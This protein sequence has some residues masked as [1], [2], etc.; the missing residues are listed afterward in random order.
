LGGGDDPDLIGRSPGAG[1][2]HGFREQTAIADETQD[3]LGTRRAAER[4]ESLAASAGQD[5]HMHAHEGDSRLDPRPPQGGSPRTGSGSLLESERERLVRRPGKP[6]GRPRRTI[7]G[8]PSRRSLTSA[9]LG[10]ASDEGTVAPPG[11][12]PANRSR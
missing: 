2:L 10:L 4:P 1:A 7:P 9:R 12:A 11:E 5:G 6:M 8:Q 3:L